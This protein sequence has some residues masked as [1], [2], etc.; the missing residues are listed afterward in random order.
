MQANMFNFSQTTFKAMKHVAWS[1]NFKF[2]NINQR[3]FHRET[4]II[5]LCEV[6]ETKPPFLLA[7]RILP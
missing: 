2:D 6:K 3:F 7:I 5:R 1:R 4:H